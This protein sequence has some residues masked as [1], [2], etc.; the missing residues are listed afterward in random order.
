M[1]HIR[2]LDQCL[3]GGMASRGV[4]I[5]FYTPNSNHSGTSVGQGQVEGTQ[6]CRSPPSGPGPR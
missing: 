3:E 2:R 1:L 6:P 4:A 5:S